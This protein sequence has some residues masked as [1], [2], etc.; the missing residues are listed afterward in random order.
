MRNK[1]PNVSVIKWLG[2][3]IAAEK[4]TLNNYLKYARQ[5]KDKTGQDMFTKLAGDE[6]Q[7]MTILEKQM[8]LLRDGQA[9]QSVKIPPSPIEQISPWDDKTTSAA[10]A[11]ESEV[12]ELALKAEKQA[13]DFYLAQS[14]KLSSA[15][16]CAL[17]RRLAEMEN[18]HYQ[19]LQAELDSI[20]KTGFWMG[21][22]EISMEVE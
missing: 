21:F 1:K 12:L 3:A 19:I 5:T 9:W 4:A 6:F 7:H 16:A 8:E 11:N 22:Q 20:N 10:Q 13:G 2:L 15:P 14:K 18:A 17:L